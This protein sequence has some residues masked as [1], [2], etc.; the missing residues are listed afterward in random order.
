MLAGTATGTATPDWINVTAYG[1]DPSGQTD[2]SSA[3]NNAIAVCP[4]G[5]VVYLPT[6]EFLIAEFP[7]GRRRQRRRAART[8]RDS[9]P[10][11]E[12]RLDSHNGII[13]V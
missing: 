13:V 10:C 6:G 5:A 2:S 9:F 7:A 1:A 4:E 3:I 11:L 12:R 8:A